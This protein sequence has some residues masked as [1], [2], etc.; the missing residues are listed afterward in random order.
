MRNEAPFGRISCAQIN[1]EALPFA[2]RTFELVTIA[3]GL[4]NVTDKAKALQEMQ[5]VLSL[6]GKV[7]V[8]EF[9]GDAASYLYLAESIRRHPNQEAPAE[10]MREAGL[11]QVSVH[12]LLAGMVAI[13][14][15]Y[16]V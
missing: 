5:R 15:G 4:R 14:T 11:E 6:G 8:W 12:N 16:A 7:M 10:S 9:S 2:N 1:A 13:H 3:F